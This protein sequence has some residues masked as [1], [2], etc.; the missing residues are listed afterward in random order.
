MGGS[1]QQGPSK[2]NTAPARPRTP[3]KVSRAST[4]AAIEEVDVTTDTDLQATAPVPPPTAVDATATPVATVGEGAEHMIVASTPV[5]SIEETNGKESDGGAGST[6]T[7]EP[8]AAAVK[9][10][11]E[12]S[13]RPVRVRVCAFAP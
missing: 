8:A 5:E 2:S 10:T 9:V 12:A 4:V 11:V 7:P 1:E 6:P 13:S 3:T